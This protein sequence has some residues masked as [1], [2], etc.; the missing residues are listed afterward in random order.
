MEEEGAASGLE[1]FLAWGMSAS[2][3]RDDD[4]LTPAEVGVRQGLTVPK[5]ASDWRLGRWI[6]KEAVRRALGAPGT[7]G[8]E[9]EILP[10]P[11][12]APVVTVLA[13]GSWPA[14]VISLSHAWGMGFAAA[15][16][17]PAR[18]GC[19]VE[20]LRPRSDAFVSDYFTAPEAALG[21]RAAASDQAAWANLIWSAKESALKAL[22]EGLRLDT[23]SVEVTVVDGPTVDGWLAF[24]VTTPGGEA[25]E[26]HWRIT[27][28]FVWTLVA[29]VR[30]G[31]VV[32][33]AGG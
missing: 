32:A 33:P 9:V 2:V 15:A 31:R 26:G 11:G 12:G 13:P 4:W 18:L 14:V 10:S 7:P 6:G 22:G 1:V 25:L 5:R 27:R 16:V 21:R 3:P 29:D 17:G 28:G 19:D 24:K 20:A 23:R 8:A 30:V